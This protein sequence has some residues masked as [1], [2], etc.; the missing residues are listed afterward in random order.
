MRAAAARRVRARRSDNLRKR[1]AALR[2][3][4]QRQRAAWF[5]ID[6]GSPYTFLDSRAAAR[7]RLATHEGAAVSGAGGGAVPVRLADRVTF[8]FDDTRVTFDG[9]RVADLSGIEAM[10]GHR[11]DGFFGYELLARFAI[12]FDPDARRIVFARDA[13][14]RRNDVVMPIRFGGTKGKWIYVRGF[15]KVAGVPEQT[16]EFFV[17][18]GSTDSVNHPL[19]RRSTAP[20]KTITVGNGIGAAGGGGVAGTVETIRFDSLV[21]H[22]VDASCCGPLPGTE[23]AIGAGVL[24]RFIVTFDYAHARLILRPRK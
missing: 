4:R 18:S 16:T 10:I 3:P 14:P 11:L 7:L 12:T 17:D 21:L 6:S 15:I 20:L 9:V 5:L 13:R 22:D 8:A 24:S 2:S 23:S 19:L 1:I